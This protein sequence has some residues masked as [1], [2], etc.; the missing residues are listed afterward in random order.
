MT[1]Y[2]KIFTLVLSFV[3]LI[4]TIGN[5]YFYFLDFSEGGRPYRV[6]IQR[7]ALEIEKEGLENVS[8]SHCK[9]VAHIEP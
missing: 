1:A 8:L 9:Y 6:E 2:R 5:L 4:F 7:L 3:I